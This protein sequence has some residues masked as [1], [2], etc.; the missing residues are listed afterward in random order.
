MSCLIGLAN[1]LARM[2]TKKDNV[3][4]EFGN[5]GAATVIFEDDRY[6]ILIPPLQKIPVRSLY[7]KYRMW[8]WHLFHEAM[9]IV[10]ETYLEGMDMKNII[11]NI[12]VDYRIEKKGLE[13]YREIY[14]EYLFK[15]AVYVELFNRAVSSISSFLSSKIFSDVA[16]AYMRLLCYA[17]AM[18]TNVIPENAKKLLEE[19]DVESIYRAIEVS[20]EVANRNI[21]DVAGRVLNIL[22]VGDGIYGVIPVKYDYL[23]Y[24]DVV[25]A[26][27]RYLKTI[28]RLD[29]V[30]D[31]VE[32]SEDIKREF[33]EILWC[34]R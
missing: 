33:K 8:R 27:E 34:L 22:N 9:H 3:F 10:D 24:K 21:Y 13:M 23:G 20:R 12:I 4:V 2:W 29:V 17:C 25:E 28:S 16:S 11:V 6:I 15:N 18:L 14:T 26:V 1:Y 5:G 32:G 7:H 30:R 31:V 19:G